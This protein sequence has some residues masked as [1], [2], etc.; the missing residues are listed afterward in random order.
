MHVAPTLPTPP[1]RLARAVVFGVALT[2]AAALA[3]ALV[4]LQVHGT[5][6]RPTFQPG[7]RLVALRLPVAWPLR[8]G[9]LVVVSHPDEG[10]LMVKR[11]SAVGPQGVEVLGD[12]PSASTDIRVWGPLPRALVRGRVLY[13]YGAGPRTR[14][15]G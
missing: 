9:D 13:R 10:R 3:R 7:D 12:N 11:V 15:S 14:S 5:S 2:A 6:M 1:R 4:R 8:P